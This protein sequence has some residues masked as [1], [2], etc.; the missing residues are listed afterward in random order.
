MEKTFDF[1]K[2][3]KRMPYSVPNDFFAKLEESVM[4]EVKVQKSESTALPERN[5]TVIIAIR[6]LL[7]IAATIALF[8]VVQP[9]L[10]KNDT[11]SADDY[12]SVEL[13]F[14]NLSSDDQDFLIVVYE[15]EEFINV[16][17]NDL[18]E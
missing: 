15:N 5:K 3:G 9:T 6:S 4:D 1:E 14:N 8:F 18:I 2:I 11:I 7:A 16:L 13:A 17:T 12:A 10:T